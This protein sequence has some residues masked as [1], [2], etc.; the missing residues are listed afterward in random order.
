MP[1]FDYLNLLV[2]TDIFKSKMTIILTPTIAEDKLLSI[3]TARF[4]HDDLL[5]AYLQ[6]IWRNYCFQFRKVK[7]HK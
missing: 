5:I 2:E 3:C 7:L 4:S 1:S 6:N